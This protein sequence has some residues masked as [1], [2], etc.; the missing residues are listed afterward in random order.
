[1]LMASLRHSN[2]RYDTAAVGI[3]LL[4]SVSMGHKALL[5]TSEPHLWIEYLDGRDAST[6]YE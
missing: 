4:R 2:K 3:P 5:R 6:K 1:M